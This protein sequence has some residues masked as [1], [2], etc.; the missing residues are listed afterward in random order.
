MHVLKFPPAACAWRILTQLI[1]Q[2]N[3]NP[4]TNAE[5]IFTKGWTIFEQCLQCTKHKQAFLQH[6][7]CMLSRSNDFVHVQMYSLWTMQGKCHSLF[8]TQFPFVL[9]TVSRGSDAEQSLALNSFYFP[10]HLLPKLLQLQSHRELKGS[11]Q[12]I[13][14]LRHK[15][16]CLSLHFPAE[17]IWVLSLAPSLRVHSGLGSRGCGG[18]SVL[19][20]VSGCT[21]HMSVNRRC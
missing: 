4:G 11:L 9:F 17:K 6:Q 8:I 16:Q 10:P 1:A 3:S 20:R 2:S 21:W 15:D 5:A 7:A 12:Q 14:F 18:S 19:S 13:F